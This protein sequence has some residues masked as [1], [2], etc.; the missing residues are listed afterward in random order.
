[1]DEGIYSNLDHF[2]DYKR[3]IL[4]FIDNYSTAGDSSLNQIDAAITC[5]N[6]RERSEGSGLRL[7]TVKDTFDLD[8]CAWFI[9]IAAFL[10]E[11]EA[12]I[13]RIVNKHT[14][15]TCPTLNFLFCLY[16][17]YKNCDVEMAYL[18]KDAYNSPLRH[19]L[20]LSYDGCYGLDMCVTLRKSVL[21]YILQGTIGDNSVFCTQTIAG[22]QI[23][24]VHEYEYEG[25]SSYISGRR[26]K[27]CLIYLY[28]PHGSGKKTLVSRAAAKYGRSVSHLD[29]GRLS[30][31]DARERHNASI[32]LGSS[33]ALLCSAICIDGFTADL[34]GILGELEGQ[35][36]E[37]PF[38]FMTGDSEL[39]PRF[40]TAPIVKMNIGPV[41][42][43]EYDSVNSILMKKYGANALKLPY[44]RLTISQ[45]MSLWEQAA[46]QASI[47]KSS[48][49]ETDIRTALYSV[50]TSV[51]KTQAVHTDITMDSL[52]LPRETKEKLSIAQKL[53]RFARNPIHQ[54]AYG[55]YTAI[56]FCG[57]S[58]TG[59]TMAASAIANEMGV[60]LLR[61]DLSQML[62]KYIGETEKHISSVFSAAKENN[63]ILFFDE[64]DAL[65]TRRTE[66]S[67][68][69]DRHANAETAYMLQC[70]EN[71]E[72][73]ILLATN[74]Y[75][76][77]D[78]AFLRRLTIVIRFPMPDC[79]LRLQLWE[80]YLNGSKLSGE[81]NC[82]A[83]A[84]CLELSPA[85]IEA[86]C[87]IAKAMAYCDGK[88]ITLQTLVDSLDIEL[89]K[90][91][92][93]SLLKEL[94]YKL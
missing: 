15:L 10:A 49:S 63:C 65:F 55:N 52:V 66:V 34:Q 29:L 27:S 7:K 44:Y 28:G 82:Q 18:Y 14:G 61:I 84:G 38:I 85:V 78:E 3:L 43:D 21:D 22:K 41:T 90:T 13:K 64:A 2:N 11:T 4:L 75:K 31:C 86:V 40:T 36:A 25:L 92:Q 26:G 42:A 16:N 80:K 23:M 53:I 58:G 62:D 88:P 70:I 76:N 45:L 73:V 71:H 56:M 17:S 72:G 39:A 67:T 6:D 94:Q 93:T 79:G 24:P 87:R 32:E 12:D 19:V 20:Q 30:E 59:K 35:I 89:D 74:L 46:M 68:S 48:I 50:N 8:G 51:S 60:E 83:I 47:E 91:G 37:C 57:E 9:T 77:I 54:R 1:M 81:V 5:M 69:N 33:A